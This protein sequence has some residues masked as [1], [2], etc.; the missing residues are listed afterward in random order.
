MNLQ[1]VHV[2]AIERQAVKLGTHV[3]MHEQ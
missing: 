3:H 2:S 1:N